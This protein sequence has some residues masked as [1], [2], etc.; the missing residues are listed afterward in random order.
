[1]Y[2]IIKVYLQDEYR[3]IVAKTTNKIA[4]HKTKFIDNGRVKNSMDSWT[5]THTPTGL[6]LRM[7][8][9]KKIADAVAKKIIMSGINLNFEPG[10][11]LKYRKA[12]QDWNELMLDIDALYFGFSTSHQYSCANTSFCHFSEKVNKPCPTDV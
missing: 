1:M 2:R 9:D 10:D 4:V 5:I 7:Y 8:S 3:R 11:L 12:K 6:A